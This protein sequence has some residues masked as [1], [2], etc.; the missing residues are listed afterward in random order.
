LRQ[1]P[2]ELTYEELMEGV[3]SNV[4]T[5]FKSQTPC[6][7]GDTKGRRVLGGLA[8]SGPATVAVQRVNSFNKTVTLECP[9]GAG[10]ALNSTFEIYGP[11]VTDFD[12]AKPLAQVVVTGLQPTETVA[13]VLTPDKLPP[14]LKAGCRA[15]MSQVGADLGTVASLTVRLL[16]YPDEEQLQMKECL[17]KL[18]Y[19]K[20]APKTDEYPDCALR[21]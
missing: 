12:G 17:E 11:D 1:A 15:L 4:Q 13:K 5:Q 19:V 6:L 10:H 2:A 20:V 7:E 16:D 3:R 14:E 8:K 21:R 9:P 18:P